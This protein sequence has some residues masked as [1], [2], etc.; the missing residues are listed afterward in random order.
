[1]KGAVGILPLRPYPEADLAPGALT[2]VA[3]GA[4]S[5]LQEAS[6]FDIIKGFEGGSKDLSLETETGLY[7]QSFFPSYPVSYQVL[8]NSKVT[9]TLENFI[10]KQK[11]HIE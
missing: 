9:I 3:V 7:L 5:S 6:A 10:D 1:M 8:S 2:R 4:S 11:S